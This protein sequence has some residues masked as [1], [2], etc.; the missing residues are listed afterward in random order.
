[1]NETI[2][3]LMKEKPPTPDVE[4]DLLENNVNYEL[5][6]QAWNKIPSCPFCKAPTALRVFPAKGKL[7]A[8]VCTNSK[9]EVNKSGWAPL[10]F[11]ICDADIYDLAP[12]VLLGTVDKLALIGQYPDTLRRIYGM[13]GAAPWREL[14]TGRLRVP[15]VL[16]HYE[17]GPAAFG[18][19]GLY[20]LL[21]TYA[22]VF[23]RAISEF[24]GLDLGSISEYLF[25]ADLAFVV[26]RNG[27]TMDLGNLSALW[28]NFNNMFL[29]HILQ[30]KT[31]MCGSGSLCDTN[32]HK[33]GACPDCVMVPETS[34]LA[35]N[36]L[37]SRSVLR[38]GPAPRE[39]KDHH[40]LTPLLCGQCSIASAC[41]SCMLN[42]HWTR[43]WSSYLS[44][45]ILV[46]WFRCLKN[47]LRDSPACK[48]R[49]MP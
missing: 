10:P 39:D 46:N 36:Q 22:H 16:T 15:M 38:G 31:L 47:P 13:F 28:R 33:P 25:P 12:S 1:M 48:P 19:E 20:T 11:Y 30:P 32:P 26:Y 23:M 40:P 17:A 14:A 21:H 35:S 45:P 24:S 44:Q 41:T 49:P 6:N 4:A 9:C 8:H 3:N 2:A 5:Q 42:G 43:L 7:L 37:L 34:C 18:C 27:T 29:E